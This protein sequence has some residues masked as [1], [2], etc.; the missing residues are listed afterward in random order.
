MIRYLVFDTTTGAITRDGFCSHEADAARQSLD[1][2]HDL[3]MLDADI[4]VSQSA[5]V[6][7]GDTLINAET[8][9]PV[10]LGLLLSE[11]AP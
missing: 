9:E 5:H 8:A 11:I 7:A 2:S 3:L 1:P 4:V 6:V 10:A